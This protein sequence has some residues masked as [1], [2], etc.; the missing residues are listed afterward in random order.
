MT[1]VVTPTTPDPDNES[2]DSE[3]RAEKKIPGLI[4]RMCSVRFVSISIVL[5]MSLL[6]LLVTAAFIGVYSMT[7]TGL[8][9]TLREQIMLRTRDYVT[10]LTQPTKLYGQL[11]FAGLVSGA[12]SP[13]AGTTNTFT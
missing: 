6:L 10:S 4:D 9:T 8:S 11:M 1:N 2:L 5:V 7:I 12:I 13:N 3:E